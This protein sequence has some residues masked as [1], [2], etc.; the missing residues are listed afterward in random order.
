MSYKATE[1]CQIRLAGRPKY[2]TELVIHEGAVPRC[3]QVVRPW[4]GNTMVS[5]DLGPGTVTCMRCERCVR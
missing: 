2:D 3:G 1:T 5:Q 4:H